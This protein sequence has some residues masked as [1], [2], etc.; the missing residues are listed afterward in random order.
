[1]PEATRV[2]ERTE[3]CHDLVMWRILVVGARDYIGPRTQ[4][5]TAGKVY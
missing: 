3:A 2:N 4:D 1:M 5:G